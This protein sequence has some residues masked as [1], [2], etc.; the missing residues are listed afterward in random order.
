VERIVNILLKHCN[1]STTPETVRAIVQRIEPL[2]KAAKP[3]RRF[4]GRSYTLAGTR[5]TVEISNR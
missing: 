4:K 3:H 1:I 2:P 5:R